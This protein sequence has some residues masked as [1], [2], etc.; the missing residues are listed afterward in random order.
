MTEDLQQLLGEIGAKLD[1]ARTIAISSHT[2]PDGDAIGS[3]IALGDALTQAGKD[4]VMLNQDG[5]P[6]KYNFLD[7]VDAVRKPGD[8][9]EGLD[10]DVFV[11]LDTADAKRVGSKV[12]KVIKSRKLMIAIDHHVSNERFADL[13]YVDIES[14]ATGQI[15]YELIRKQGWPLSA[16]TRD[17][18]WVAIVTDTGSFQY[19]NTTARTLEIAAD[20]IREGVK[21]GWISTQIYQNYPYRRLKLLGE[22]LKTLER[23]DC[24]RIAS[25]K[26]RRATLDELE[27]R[28]DD[29]EGLIDDLRSIDG[30]IVAVSFEEGADGNIQISTR[31]KSTAADVSAICQK[32]GGGGH[33]LAAGARAEGN[34]DEVAERFLAV[35]TEC[36]RPND[37]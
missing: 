2:R 31:S 14:P 1:A 37:E 5:V 16:V 26:L 13:N 12:W 32:F 27:I 4:V 19:E 29:T 20:L 10:V 23:S 15:V 11:V 8:L 25:W 6:Y 28:S 24:G 3:L 22:L 7:G 36:L 34:I 21:V 18:L 9:D 17:H 33:R 30:V 35:V